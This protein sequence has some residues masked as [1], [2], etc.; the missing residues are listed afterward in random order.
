[1]SGGAF[2]GAREECPCPLCGADRPERAGY[3]ADG[4]EAVRCGACG[5]WYLSPRLT[6]E[7]MLQAYARDDY[8]EGGESGYAAYAAQERSLRGTFARLL[9]EMRG[10]GMT[11]G[12]LLDVGCGYGYLLEEAAGFFDVRA[13][14]DFSPA[15]A[16]EA[17]GRGAEVWV[18]GVEAV[19]EGR[20]FDCVTALHVVEHVYHPHDFVQA[21]A[22][23]VRPGGWLVLAAPDMGSFWRKGMGRRWP[24]W[25]FPEHVMFYDRRSLER[26]ARGL[27]RVAELRPLPYPHA[28]PV[29]EVAA[30]LGLRA[31][32]LLASRNLWLPATTVAV[33]AR[34][35]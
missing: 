7:A 8:F 9:R 24:S 25:K 1:M 13:G 33:A 35:S 29:A 11:G 18:G 30:K 6:E 28:F 32:G 16:E 15:A 4:F 26:L 3:R 14:T 19:P 17:R 12:S 34:L 20:L 5:A 21:L 2:P 10:R 22:G 31:P 23:R 27:P